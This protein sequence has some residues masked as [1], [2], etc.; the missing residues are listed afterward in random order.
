MLPVDVRRFTSRAAES[1]RSERLDSLTHISYDNGH[2]MMKMPVML[3]VGAC[4]FS[5]MV[6][7]A[8][9]Q[10]QAGAPSPGPSTPAAPAAP[11]SADALSEP[12]AAPDWLQPEPDGPAPT[13]APTS[14]PVM[15]P[16]PTEPF[17]PWTRTD[18]Q[19]VSL[20]RVDG[21]SR[22]G[23]EVGYVDL[24]GADITPL[25]FSLYGQA[26][27][28]NGLGGF[29]V[30][31]FSYASGEGDSESSLGNLEAGAI[32]AA[33]F[34]SF[35]GIGR[36][37]IVFPTA[38]DDL[39]NFIVNA[40][41]SYSRLTDVTHASPNVTW[42]RLAFSPVVRRGNIL[43]RADAGLD[44]SIHSEDDTD[45][46][47]ILRANLALGFIQRESQ[48]SAELVSLFPTNDDDDESTLH[49]LGFTY[50]GTFDR[51]SPYAGIF[52]FLGDASDIGSFSLTGGVSTTFGS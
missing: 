35:D 44:L 31:D 7:H 47:P 15:E 20:D 4:L 6:A 24:D 42:L 12:A 49:A 50:R 43:F 33:H 1:G 34:S 32:Y 23:L 2:H 46:D 21:V 22:A 39:S 41:G 52:L 27:G 26:V 17:V 18:A 36:A 48:F 9:V 29:G 45:V 8:G 19:F 30:L 38:S 3:C 5:G 11:A 13:P 16:V 51:I 14:A 40:L 37:S 10:S 25:R 28:A